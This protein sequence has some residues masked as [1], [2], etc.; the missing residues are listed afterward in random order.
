MGRRSGGSKAYTRE[1]KEQSMDLVR[2][3]GYEP[4][5]AARQLGMPHSTLQQWLKR[6]GWVRPAEPGSPPLPD[7]PAALKVQVAD[8]QRQVKRLEMEKE[9]LKKATA[10]FASLNASVS[11][12]STGDEGSSR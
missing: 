3:Q 1:F 7:D 6:A 2:V 5:V 12:S 4:A 11:P 8:L 10:Y 9:I